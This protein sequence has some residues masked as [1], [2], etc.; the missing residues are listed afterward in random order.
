MT[1]RLRAASLWEAT[2]VERS[3]I[4]EVRALERALQDC[5]P[6]LIDEIRALRDGRQVLL[7]RI[8]AAIRGVQ[9]TLPS[10]T[11]RYVPEQAAE[12]SIEPDMREGT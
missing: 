7:D 3:L 10:G 4:E 11:E 2:T 6:S 8:Q 12:A 9:V 5:P 1:E